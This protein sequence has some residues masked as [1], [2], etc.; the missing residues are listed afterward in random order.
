MS[1]RRPMVALLGAAAGIG[2]GLAASRWLDVVEVHGS[3]MAPSLLPG[4]RLVVE[5]RSFSLRAPRAGEVVLARDP[6]EPGRELI[7]RV[8]AVSDAGDAADLRGD[9]P[10]ESTDS[11]EFGAVP[12]SAIRWRAAL[13]YWPPQRA[14]LL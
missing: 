10:D 3:S 12:L 13:R 6:R 2:A 4:D 14:G 8:F 7:K 1:R 5:C 9:A 11:R